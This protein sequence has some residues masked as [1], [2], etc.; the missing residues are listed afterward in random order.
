MSQSKDYLPKDEPGLDAWFQNWKT[1]MN[2]S[3]SQHGFSADEIKQVQDDGDMAHNVIAGTAAVEVNRREFIKFKRLML[4][5]SKNA[6]TPAYPSMETPALPSLN[7]P[8]MA[9]IVERTRSFVRR[10]KESSNYNEAV[11]ADFRVLPVESDDISEQ[12][13]QPAL[14]ARTLAQ[15]NVDIDFVRGKFDGL[16]IERQRGD[17][18]N[19]WQSIGRFYKS[20]AEDDAPPVEAN[21]PETRR[22]RARFLIGNQPVG[23]YSDIISVVT[24]P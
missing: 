9:G 23:V 5:G 15:S 8:L 20:P 16:E 11:G 21:K 6:P 12:D 24:Q 22:Y 18:A 13:A 17:N 10:L 19:D 7:L 1:K 4:Y 14:K 3:G 2:E